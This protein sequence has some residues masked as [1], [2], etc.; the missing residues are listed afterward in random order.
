MFKYCSQPGLDFGKNRMDLEIRSMNRKLKVLSYSDDGETAHCKIVSHNR[1][2]NGLPVSLPT[3]YLTDTHVFQEERPRSYKKELTTYLARPF[4]TGGLND[5]EANFLKTVE[6]TAALIATGHAIYSPV[7]HGYPLT[8]PGSPL[9]NQ[10]S[11]FH[12]QLHNYAFLARCEQFMI[13]KLGEWKNSI[14]VQNDILRWQKSNPHQNMYTIDTNA[15][16]AP[17]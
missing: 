11:S 16:I 7:V 14:G 1:Y 4:S 12:W 17:L 10:H 15:V 13:F 9:E 3:K 5:M 6:I 8:Y 2:E